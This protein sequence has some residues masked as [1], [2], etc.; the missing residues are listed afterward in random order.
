[1]L[2]VTN[3]TPDPVDLLCQRMGT[4]EVMIQTSMCPQSDP[5]TSPPSED[6]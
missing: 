4:V 6:E 5:V 1:M 2:S 3:V